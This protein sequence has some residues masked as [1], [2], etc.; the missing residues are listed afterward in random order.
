MELENLPGLVPADNDVLTMIHAAP[1][2][3][4]ADKQE[5]NMYNGG[6]QERKLWAGFWPTLTVAG[7]ATS[8]RTEDDG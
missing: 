1:H 7:Q 2:P 3:V 5:H 4:D 8:T 6:Q